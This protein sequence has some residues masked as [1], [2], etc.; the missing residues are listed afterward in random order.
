MEDHC[1]PLHWHVN[2]FYCAAFLYVSDCI[3]SE[4][5]SSAA[6][7]H[8]SVRTPVSQE[9]SLTHMSNFLAVIRL[10]HTYHIFYQLTP[11][12]DIVCPLIS[13]LV[14]SFALHSM[15]SFATRN[16]SPTRTCSRI[17]TEF[18]FILVNASAITGG[19]CHDFRWGCH[20]LW[21]IYSK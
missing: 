7:P 10:F 3:L 9:L 11:E 18:T 20:S 16:Y 14:T 15:I 21:D 2:L 6:D 4:Q 8:N 12:E 5:A 1:L 19:F 17:Q 13:A